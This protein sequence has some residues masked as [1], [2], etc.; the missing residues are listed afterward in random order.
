MD[1]VRL[2]RNIFLRTFVIGAAFGLVFAIVTIVAW[3]AWMSL[4]TR[5]FHTDAATMTP[6][7][8]RFFTQLRFFLWF[9][10]LTPGLALHWTLKAEEKRARLGVRPPI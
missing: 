5:C 3:D 1:V 2:L 6:L 7:A 9:G 10:L 4:A 8:L